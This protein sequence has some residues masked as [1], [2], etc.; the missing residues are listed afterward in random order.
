MCDLMRMCACTS[1]ICVCV[2]MCVPYH[3]LMCGAC[4]LTV[5]GCICVSAC[6]SDDA[7][8]CVRASYVYVSAL[9]RVCIRECVC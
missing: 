6:V 7:V 2:Y 5:Y 1:A 4:V 8:L 9:I 3:M